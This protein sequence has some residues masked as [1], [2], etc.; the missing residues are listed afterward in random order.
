[1]ARAELVAIASKSKSTLEKARSK[2]ST[3]KHYLDYRELRANPDV[4]VVAIVVPSH[5]HH[6]VASLALTA[7]KHVLL[8]KP[9]C[10]NLDL[11]DD[12][13]SAA[14]EKSRLLA[15]RHELRL[16]SLW[17]RVK[18]MIDDGFVGSQ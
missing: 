9:M 12:L 3:A 13:I 14:Q 4:D 15:I 10:L 2:Y 1:M 17:S 8:E 5:L 11:C 18:Q 7:G 6:E 16:S